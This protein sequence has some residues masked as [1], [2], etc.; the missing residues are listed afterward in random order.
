[1]TRHPLQSVLEGLDYQPAPGFREALR[2]QLLADLSH[3]DATQADPHL[4]A[5]DGADESQ[6]I[7]VL[8]KV[9]RSRSTPPRTRALLAMAASVIVVAG[10]TAI[11]VNHR[12]SDT[13]PAENGA[14]FAI[15]GAGLISVDQ[16][17][18]GWRREFAVDPSWTGFQKLFVEQPQCRS[19]P[20]LRTR[21]KRPPPEQ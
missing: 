12:S 3:T 20:L 6:E 1:M 2:A 5:G 11:V 19:T 7:T 18:P 9:D 8:K 16:L 14:D 4:D 17:G 13:P 10:V 21:P 15:A